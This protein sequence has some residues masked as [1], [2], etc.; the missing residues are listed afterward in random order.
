MATMT[1]RRAFTLIELLTVMAIIAVL[2][3]MLLPALGSAKAQA[4]AMRCRNNHKQLQLAWLLYAGDYD[5]R[6]VPHGQLL[7]GPA[8]TAPPYWWAQGFMSFAEGN[9][10]N[11][12]VA[13]LT[14]PQ[15][16][17]LGDYVR[18]P[19]LY[20]CP[21]DRSAARLGG[22]LRP[23]VRSVSMNVYV[24]RIIDCLGNDPIQ[25]GPRTVGQIPNASRQFVFLDE[26]PDSISGISFWVSPGEGPEAKIVSYPGTLHRGDGVL[27]FADGHVE[28]RRWRD[29]R[30]KP[31]VKFENWLADEASAGNP[32]IAWL[33][34]HTFF[35]EDPPVVGE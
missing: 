14:D 25:M 28:S 8:L 27:S 6:I 3:A 1:S 23:R 7:P 10:D 34:Q 18:T 19:A 11:T 16:A 32:D 33:Q 4:Y 30:T 24:G 12:N 13:L 21:A 9:T 26:H 35:P 31:P 15:Y 20:Q 22:V 2:A 29:P 17:R 5:D